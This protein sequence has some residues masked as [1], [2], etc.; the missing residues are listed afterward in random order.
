M[1]NFEAQPTKTYLYGISKLVGKLEADPITENITAFIKYEVE[2]EC[3]SW[4][5]K[6][7]GV[8][9]QRIKFDIE[10]EYL[11]EELTTEEIDR[12]TDLGGIVNHYT[13]RISLTFEGSEEGFTVVN[14]VEFARSGCL[15]INDIAI[16]L[17]RQTI[18]LENANVY[19][20]T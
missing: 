4:G 14:E 8:N 2:F 7:G 20:L 17:E 6:Y 15:S 13:G 12:L 16:D 18:T 9:I 1:L 11:T 3:R 19:A 5:I 10:L